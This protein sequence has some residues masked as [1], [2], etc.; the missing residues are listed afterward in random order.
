MPQNLD[1]VLVTYTHNMSLNGTLTKTTGVHMTLSLK[2]S[3]E[4]HGFVPN[5]IMSGLQISRRE[6]RGK[7]GAKNVKV[8]G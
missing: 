8:L 7:D 3:I 4:Q 1:R 5:V 6:S 2:P